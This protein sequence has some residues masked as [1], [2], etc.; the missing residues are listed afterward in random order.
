MASKG[1]KRTGDKRSHPR[2][3]EPEDVA[4]LLVGQIA[5]IAQEYDIALSGRKGLRE[6]VEPQPELGPASQIVGVGVNEML[7]RLISE[8]KQ[9][10]WTR[11]SVLDEE[12]VKRIFANI[13]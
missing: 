3:R 8:T 13:S 6:L 12:K 9:L 4:D 2:G 11:N 7:K 10:T 1:R 5:L